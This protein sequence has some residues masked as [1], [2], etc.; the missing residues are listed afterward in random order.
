MRLPVRL[1]V[2]YIVGR[3]EG[4]SPR[5]GCGRSQK[6][7]VRGISLSFIEK[8]MIY[9]IDQEWKVISSFPRH[10]YLVLVF[11]LGLIFLPFSFDESIPYFVISLSGLG[12]G[13]GQG[14][15][16][17]VADLL[18]WVTQLSM[19]SWMNKKKKWEFSLSWISQRLWQRE[20]IFAPL[21][22]MNE[23]RLIQWNKISWLRLFLFIQCRNKTSPSETD[24][25][26]SPLVETR[27]RD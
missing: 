14:F 27:F 7:R 20:S 23:R 10:P 1:P 15:L 24:N 18:E 25:S 6:R 8:G 16:I 22:L 19:R 9:R 4:R 12:S 26:S 17:D 11:S 2:S 5:L 21:S 13:S 3:R